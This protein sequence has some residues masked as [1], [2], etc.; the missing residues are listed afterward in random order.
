MVLELLMRLC[1]L[2]PAPGHPSRKY[3]GI[4][5]GGAKDRSTVVSTATRRKLGYARPKRVEPVASPVK[6]A[7]LLRRVWGLDALECAPCGGRMTA[8]A[9]V[10][11]PEQVAR[12]LAHT[13]DTTL[14]Q[15]ARAPPEWAA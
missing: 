11:D 4:L 12:Y 10:E 5:G 9:V 15:R 8:M 14:H 1:S 13:G 3:F 6:W 2:V 7:E